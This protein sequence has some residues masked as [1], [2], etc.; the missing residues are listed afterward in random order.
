MHDFAIAAP[1]AGMLPISLEEVGNAAFADRVDTKFVVPARDVPTLLERL[2]ERCCILEVG[3]IRLL[4]YSTLFFDTPGLMLYHAHH[5]ARAPR[6]KVRVRSYVDSGAS[7]LEVKRKN[8]R[9][10]TAKDRVPVDADAVSDRAMPLRHL[11]ER[12]PLGVER[13]VPI[14]ELEPSLRVEFTRMTL[15]SRDAPERLTIDLDLRFRRNG[16]Q[17][18]LPHLAIVELKQEREGRSPLRDAIRSVYAQPDALSKYCLGIARLEPQVRRNNFLPVIR[19]IDRLN[20]HD[21]HER[22][23]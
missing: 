13:A 6:F 10:R 18:A 22:L 21:P 16:Y 12:R 3:G 9:G 17:A 7:F 4:R 23:G 15:A 20:G 11:A 5:A 8:N 2:V 19:R 1:V 14:A